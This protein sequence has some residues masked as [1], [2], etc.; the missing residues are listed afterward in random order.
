[1][2]QKGRAWRGN[3]SQQVK[4]QEEA[5]GLRLIIG[6]PWDTTDS[7]WDVGTTGVQSFEPHL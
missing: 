4:G 5:L 6:A 7:C 2:D 3:I 1:M